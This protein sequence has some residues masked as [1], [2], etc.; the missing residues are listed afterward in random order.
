MRTGE[1]CAL[2]W[3]DVDLD[4]GIIKIRTTYMINLKMKKADGF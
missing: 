2:T 3:D 1:V 4:K